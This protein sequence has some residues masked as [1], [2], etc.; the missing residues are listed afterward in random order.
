MK[1]FVTG[2]GWLTAAGMG[3]GNDSFAAPPGLVRVPTGRELF[4]SPDARF[5][6]MDKFSKTGVAA[7]SMALQD[8][9][10]AMGLE[11]LEAGIIAST[12]FGCIET[13]ADF[14][15]TVIAGAG[16]WASPQLFTYTLPSCFLGEAA[17]RFGLTGP[18]Y[19]VYSD[20][21]FSLDG[22]RAALQEMEDSG[23][24]IMAAGAC[25]P[26]LSEKLERKFDDQ[27]QSPAG[28]AFIVLESAPGPEARKCS[29]IEEKSGNI[30]V[31]NIRVESLEKL[32][33]LVQKTGQQNP[34]QQ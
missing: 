7:V 12:R 3:R 5:G 4:H 17:L 25:D 24:G 16:K 6:R 21:C 29:M 18:S 33:D 28:A 19:I 23:I 22:V 9:G 20:A 31:N 13:D 27:S 1:I 30:F 8:A 32:I 11:G 34:A 2:M 15:R 14:F 26:P 10:S